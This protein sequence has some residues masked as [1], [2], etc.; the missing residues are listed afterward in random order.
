M[1]VRHQEERLTCKQIE[2]WGAGLVV[3]CFS[4]IFAR[5]CHCI[6]AIVPRFFFFNKVQPRTEDWH[7]A[8]VFLLTIFTWRKRPD[9]ET[10]KKEDFEWN[11]R[12]LLI[13]PLR[14]SDLKC[15]CEKGEVWHIATKIMFGVDRGCSR[16]PWS[17]WF[18]ERYVVWICLWFQWKLI[19][20]VV[21]VWIHSLCCV[22]GTGWTS[23]SFTINN[24]TKTVRL[25]EPNLIAK[26]Q[27][28]SWWI[29]VMSMLHRIVIFCCFMF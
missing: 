25:S 1:V 14:T 10:V 18:S 26:Y 7:T 15:I 24:Y 29:F 11:W 8:T 20:L 19:E 27:P 22:S 3:R 9:V 28:Q 6:T 4:F 17:C 5:R 12:E 23:L 2:W 21:W 16:R 13:F